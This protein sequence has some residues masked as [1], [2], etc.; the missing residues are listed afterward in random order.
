MLFSS[1][2]LIAYW[3]NTTTFLL[4]LSYS[5][6]YM[7]ATSISA[8]VIHIY[9]LILFSL[10]IFSFFFSLV[11]SFLFLLPFLSFPVLF[12]L[13]CPVL[14]CLILSCPILSRS[15][16]SLIF[17]FPLNRVLSQLKQRL[18]ARATE[19]HPSL[20]E[21]DSAEYTNSLLGRKMQLQVRDDKMFH[22]LC[23]TL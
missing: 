12:V 17:L 2:S 14:F 20:V 22:C 13:S 21:E 3:L 16:L 15:V 5:S 18:F 4:Y 9:K 23:R 7:D 11:L 8:I 19:D 1:P 10:L 6:I